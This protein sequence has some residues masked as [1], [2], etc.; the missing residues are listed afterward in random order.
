MG[1]VSLLQYHHGFLDIPVTEMHPHG[2]LRHRPSTTPFDWTG[3]WYLLF[4]ER[5]SQLN[6]EGIETV[7]VHSAKKMN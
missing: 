5:E 1:E 4:R 3:P 6:N 7:A 2:L